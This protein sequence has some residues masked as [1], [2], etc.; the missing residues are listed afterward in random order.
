MGSVGPKDPPRGRDCQVVHSPVHGDRTRF[1]RAVHGSH[2]NVLGHTEEWPQDRNGGP[3]ECNS[4]A[5]RS[6]GTQETCR[7]RRTGFT[8]LL[9]IIVSIGLVI[10]TRADY[11]DERPWDNGSDWGTQSIWV[12]WSLADATSCAEMGV[13]GSGDVQVEMWVDGGWSGANSDRGHG[14]AGDCQ[15]DDNGP[16]CGTATGKANFWY[17]EGNDWID[18]G[19]HVGISVFTQTCVEG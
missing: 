9:A 5:R 10:V 4:P 7:M 17:I 2:P 19:Q 13:N 16:W 14:G 3:P 1:A 8:A 18:Y 15:P 12:S 11:F 6:S